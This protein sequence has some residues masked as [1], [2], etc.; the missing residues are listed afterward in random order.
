MYTIGID[1]CRLLRH[2]TVRHP[3][4]IVMPRSLKSDEHFRRSIVALRFPPPEQSW[5]FLPARWFDK[6]KPKK[7]V[8]LVLEKIT[9][10]REL[11]IVV[12]WPSNVFLQSEPGFE[13]DFTRTLAQPVIDQSKFDNLSV[14][15]LQSVRKGDK[16]DDLASR[17]VEM[18]NSTWKNEDWDG[19]HRSQHVFDRDRDEEKWDGIVRGTKW[20]TGEAVW[21]EA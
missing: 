17:V 16:V 9:G 6:G 8:I 5:G 12:D 18:H 7:D 19:I 15:L 13:E 4:L 21:E 3:L 10:L 1:K 2:I 14:T 20:K 11:N